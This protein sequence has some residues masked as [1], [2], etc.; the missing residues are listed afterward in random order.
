MVV[1]IK[2][3]SVHVL[4]AFASWKGWICR[5][6]KFIAFSIGLS[7]RSE[8]KFVVF[9]RRIAGN[10]D[11]PCNDIAIYDGTPGRIT[12][13]VVNRLLSIAHWLN[14]DCT[15]SLSTKLFDTHMPLLGRIKTCNIWNGYTQLVPGPMIYS[16]FF[17]RFDLFRC[18]IYLNKE[19]L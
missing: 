14:R 4:A 11:I 3:L 19:K 10:P 16:Q 2:R 1:G 17:F 5:E 18:I 9:E 7:S 15:V 8:S 13:F 12:I 6:E